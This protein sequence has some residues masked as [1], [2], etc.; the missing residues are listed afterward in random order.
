V[1]EAKGAVGSSGEAFLAKENVS[2]TGGTWT[3]N[4]SGKAWQ[5]GDG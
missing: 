3:T 4:Q 1:T 5:E 2:G